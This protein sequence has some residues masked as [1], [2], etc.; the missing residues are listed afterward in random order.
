M[1]SDPREI[2][3]RSEMSFFQ[4]IIIAIMVGLNSL[5][6]FDILSITFASSR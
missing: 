1:H 5:D 4:I 3:N 2:M 6:G